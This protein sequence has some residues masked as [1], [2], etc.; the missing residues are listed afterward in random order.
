MKKGIHIV[1]LKKKATKKYMSPFYHLLYI[2]Y[3]FM[4]KARNFTK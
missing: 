2:Q 4:Q 3:E 1:N